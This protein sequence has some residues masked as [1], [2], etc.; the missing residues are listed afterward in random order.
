MTLKKCIRMSWLASL[1]SSKINVTAKN[2]NMRRRTILPRTVKMMPQ[3]LSWHDSSL[4]R[5]SNVILAISHRERMR[6]HCQILNS[7]Q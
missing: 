1:P 7:R 3:R 2:I 4:R 5:S 6:S